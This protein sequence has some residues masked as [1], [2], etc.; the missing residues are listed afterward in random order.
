MSW[1][2]L[3]LR[4]SLVDEIHVIALMIIIVWLILGN[5]FNN[6]KHNAFTCHIFLLCTYLKIIKH[7]FL[8]LCTDDPAIM[9][10]ILSF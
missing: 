5:I 3:D 7:E 6:V 2:K 8:I 1:A 9:S 4:P 10:N